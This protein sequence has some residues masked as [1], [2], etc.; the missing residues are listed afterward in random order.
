MIDLLAH[1][2]L[3]TKTLPLSLLSWP[4]ADLSSATDKINSG[5]ITRFIFPNNLFLCGTEVHTSDVV[6]VHETHC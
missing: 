1:Q 3:D 4:R 5:W 6:S 2:R